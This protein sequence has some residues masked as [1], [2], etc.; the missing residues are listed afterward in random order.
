MYIAAIWLHLYKTTAT[1]KGRQTLLTTRGALINSFFE[2]FKSS[3]E[4]RPEDVYS[5]IWLRVPP[6]QLR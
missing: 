2:G 6:D 4:P 3:S 5:A 1:N